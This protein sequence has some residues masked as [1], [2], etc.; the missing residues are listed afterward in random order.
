MGPVLRS[1]ESSLKLGE[2]G[3]V[4]IVVTVE[5]EATATRREFLTFGGH[6]VGI[7]G[8]DFFREGRHFVTA[9][10]DGTLKMWDAGPIG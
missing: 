1:A 10:N 3:K 5:V 2:V 4:N 7:P 8:L 6:P 9:R